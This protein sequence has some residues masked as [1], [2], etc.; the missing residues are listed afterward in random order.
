MVTD[1]PSPHRRARSLLTQYE[2][3]GEMELAISDCDALLE[4]DPSHE[5]ARTKR[6]RM[7]ESRG[8]HADARTEVCALQLN[9]MKKNRDRLR[10]GEC[11]C[12]YVRVRRR[13]LLP[14]SQMT[15]APSR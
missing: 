9:F 11:V 6:M 5:K 13:G 2:R 14:I 12:V 8:D 4:L 10:M 15:A 7:F 3:A 1:G